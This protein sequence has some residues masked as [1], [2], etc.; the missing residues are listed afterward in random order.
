MRNIKLIIFSLLFIWAG[1]ACA[2]EIEPTKTYYYLTYENNKVNNIEILYLKEEGVYFYKSCSLS[3]IDV[4][5]T[6]SGIWEMISDR[7][8]LLTSDNYLS[9]SE[10]MKKLARAFYFNNTLLEYQTKMYYHSGNRLSFSEISEEKYFWHPLEKS[11]LPR[12]VR[13]ILKNLK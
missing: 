7:E 11:K 2:F 4:C 12:D 6:I 8:I 9:L 13:K 10:D 1:Y 5:D 3:N